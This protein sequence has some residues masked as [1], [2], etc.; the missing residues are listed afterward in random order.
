LFR[1]LPEHREVLGRPS[2]MRR[3][4]ALGLAGLLAIS[5]THEVR[6]ERMVQ[7]GDL[8]DT[9]AT[10]VVADFVET[11]KSCAGDK[12]LLGVLTVLT[13]G[14]VYFIV[15]AADNKL[16]K[17]ECPHR[18]TGYDHK[19]TFATAFPVPSAPRRVAFR[20][21]DP[22]VLE[23][24]DHCV[25]HQPSPGDWYAR[26]ARGSTYLEKDQVIIDDRISGRRSVDIHDEPWMKLGSPGRID[27]TGE[28]LIVAGTDDKEC[29]LVTRAS[30]AATHFDDCK[31]VS[32]LDPNTVW[33]GGRIVDA[34]T[35]EA[36]PAEDVL[37]LGRDLGFAEQKRDVV[38]V[39]RRHP[40]RVLATT[41]PV[42]IIGERDQVTIIGKH[43]VVSIRPD[44]N[45]AT[46][47]LPIVAHR[48]L[49]VR[50]DFALVSVDKQLE[51]ATIQ[52]S[53]GT[54]VAR[55]RER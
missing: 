2:C 47:P 6:R 16:G 38:E 55:T 22:C 42:G 5:C 11:E 43:E 13:L 53:T 31:Y 40:W 34:E 25:T 45:V 41:T 54:L 15:E 28:R 46:H 17:P 8:T 39:V 36:H 51:A 19:K 3:A 24:D 52:L 9:G 18:H 48:V 50:G 35:G 7:R 20:R 10:I 26:T 1:I 30:G 33:I 21:P 44:G 14:L 29:W 32:W 12:V 37:W 27:P 4:L 23:P 49:D